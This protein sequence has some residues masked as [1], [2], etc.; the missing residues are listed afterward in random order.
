MVAE[1]SCLSG[2]SPQKTGEVGQRLNI[3]IAEDNEEALHLLERGIRRF[4]AD[5]PIAI[6]S[7]DTLEEACQIER[8]RGPMTM[9]LIDLQLKDSASENTMR[10][11]RQLGKCVIVMSGLASGAAYRECKRHGARDYIEKPI[12]MEL[13]VDKMTRILDNMVPD[14]DYIEVQHRAQTQLQQK[15]A[16]APAAIA[17]AVPQEPAP[18]NKWMKVGVAVIATGVPII[19]AMCGFIFGGWEKASAMGADRQSGKDRMER[20]EVDVKDI[21]D[22][23]RDRDRKQESMRLD[24]KALVTKAGLKSEDGN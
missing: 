17:V 18:V 22:T 5:K 11:I 14:G 21:K 23:N 16:A 3:L 9:S 7:T 15:A 6:F 1:T 4:F 8:T 19:S 2:D 12:V 20:I 24:I 13:L 10:H